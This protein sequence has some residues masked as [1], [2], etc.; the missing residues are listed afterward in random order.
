MIDVEES[1]LAEGQSLLPECEDLEFARAV[2]AAH[3]DPVARPYRFMR[4]RA[5]AVHRDFATFA[6][7][8]RERPGLE[9]PGCE[10]PAI[11]PHAGAGCGG[12]TVHGRGLWRAPAF[13]ASRRPCARGAGRRSSGVAS[14]VLDRRISLRRG[15][16]RDRAFMVRSAQ[17]SFVGFG[18]YGDIIDRWLD[19][20]GVVSLVAEDARSS[21]GFAIVAPHRFLGLLAPRFVEL[22]AIVV[23]PAFRGGG[24]GRSLLDR[25]E[26]VARA[27]NAREV[28]LHTAREN[29]GAQRFFEKAGYRPRDAAPI[30]YPRGQPAIEMTRRLR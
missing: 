6:S 22:V 15:G 26:L 24:L 20:Y 27:W 17:Q 8:L 14:P 11:D 5:G 12:G 9:D 4:A 28:R 3:G 25:A 10:Q 29:H 13:G 23:E 7:L 18:D 21:R 1:G 19:A 30:F 16:D 2:L